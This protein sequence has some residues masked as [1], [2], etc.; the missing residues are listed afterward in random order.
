MS[1]AA[2]IKPGTE[3]PE[4]RRRPQELDLFLFCAAMWVPHRIHYDRDYSR[5]EGHADLVVNGPL[6]GG[7]LVQV[8]SNWAAT[9]GG[10]IAALRYRNRRAVLVGEPLVCRGTV[11]EVRDD[12]AGGWRAVCEVW[13]ERESD[14]ERT[15]VGSAEVI[16]R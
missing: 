6:Q 14:G 1:N 8:V 4:M 10:R 3:L 13:V 16:P 2:A 15:T 9:V 5:T 7:Y 12:A 11:S